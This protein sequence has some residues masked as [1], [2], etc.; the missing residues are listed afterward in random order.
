MPP[1]QIYKRRRV[2]CQHP[3][4]DQ[5]LRLQTGAGDDDI[6]HLPRGL[7][8]VGVGCDRQKEDLRDGYARITLRPATLRKKLR[9]ELASTPSHRIL[10]SDQPVPLLTLQRRAPG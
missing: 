8:R 3:P 10:T 9:I 5:T 1:T 2:A 6:I 7:D 4:D